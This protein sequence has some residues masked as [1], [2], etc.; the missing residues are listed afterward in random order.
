MIFE[1]LC[2]GI[3]EG[4]AGRRQKGHLPESVKSLGKPPQII[5][6]ASIVSAMDQHRITPTKPRSRMRRERAPQREI[7]D[8]AS[9]FSIWP[10]YS[11]TVFWAIE[12]RAKQVAVRFEKKL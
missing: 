12:R 5:R 7:S 11:E 3:R 10:A 2:F 4:R 9:S 1:N 8:L 6:L